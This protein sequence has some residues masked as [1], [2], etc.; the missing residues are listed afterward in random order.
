MTCD[1]QIY[2]SVQFLVWVYL[3]IGLLWGL[4]SLGI[5]LATCRYKH[6]FI[7]FFAHVHTTI[8]KMVTWPADIHLI[9]QD[10]KAWRKMSPE[11]RY[12]KFQEI[13]K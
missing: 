7:H 11:E 13:R 4:T 1:Y 10:T 5:G 2:L 3:A 12:K 9:W 8:I 6:D